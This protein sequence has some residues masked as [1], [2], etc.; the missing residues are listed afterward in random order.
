MKWLIKK[1]T[2]KMQGRVLLSLLLLFCVVSFFL[3]P[4]TARGR[5]LVSETEGKAVSEKNKAAIDKP[6]K[7]AIKTQEDLG[8]LKKK[9]WVRVGTDKVEVGDFTSAEFKPQVKLNRWGNEAYMQVG[10]PETNIPAQEKSVGLQGD[11]VSWKSSKIGADFYKKDQRAVKVRDNKNKEHTFVLSQDG[12]FEFEVVLY[13]KPLSNV[14]S[15]PIEAK[16]LKFYYQGPLTDEE[17]AQG[18]VRPDEIAGSYAVYHES[19]KDGQYATGKAFHIYR[20]KIID[21]NGDW[22]WGELN[23]DTKSQVLKI[24]IDSGWLDK[25]AYPV[26][27]DPEFGYTSI[28]SSAI[29]LENMMRGSIFTA[30]EFTPASI[31][32]YLENTDLNAAHSAKFAIYKVSDT[33]LVGQTEE[34]TVPAGGKG[35]YEGLYTT[36]FNLSAEQYAL[37]A[38][39]N[40]GNILIYFDSGVPEQSFSQT[41]DYSLAWPTTTAG[42]SYDDKIYSIWDANPVSFNITVTLGD[43][44]PPTISSTAP[45]TNAYINSSTVSYTF[46]EAA[47]SS[48]N[49]KIT[50]TRTGGTADA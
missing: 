28:G 31:T 34:V 4:L 49:T 9:Y 32:A 40:N 25:A 18:I 10:V 36:S 1:I 26:T 39:G 22:V 41:K 44:T 5:V 24:T 38:N 27:I 14:I 46:S 17:K 7:G 37:A 48:A 12:G 23:I 47:A 35:W 13:E 15:L 42:F 30:L 8:G 16:G 50:F 21:I 3:F 2:R 19:K 29:P 20:P 6:V 33:N 43:T 11:R 45:A